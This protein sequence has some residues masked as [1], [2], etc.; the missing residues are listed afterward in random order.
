MTKT[1][2]KYNKK[3]RKTLR[4][5]QHGGNTLNIVKNVGKVGKVA[6]TVITVY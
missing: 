1:R 2:K 6:T 3:K 5:N 4:G